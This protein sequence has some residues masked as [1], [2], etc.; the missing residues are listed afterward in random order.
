MDRRI[1]S[2]LDLN[3]CRVS[4]IFRNPVAHLLSHWLLAPLNEANERG[5]S[6]SIAK[7]KFR[8]ELLNSFYHC[9][10]MNNVMP[11]EF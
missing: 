8:G 4:Q 10:Y 2:S 6:F 1:G 7:I 3:R 5:H 9:Y 11:P